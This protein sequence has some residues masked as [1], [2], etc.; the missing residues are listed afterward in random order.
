MCSTTDVSFKSADMAN[1]FIYF[2]I[3]FFNV[4]CAVSY[5]ANKTIRSLTYLL[6]ILLVYILLICLSI[7]KYVSNL[8]CLSAVFASY[9]SSDPRVF[10]CKAE[11]CLAN[12]SN[13]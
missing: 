6:N 12:C 10:C 3:A 9:Y 7:G 8:G 5:M 13:E 2:F 11:Y 4:E 1:I